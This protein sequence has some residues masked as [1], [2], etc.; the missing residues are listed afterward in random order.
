MRLQI[1]S[2]ESDTASLALF[3]FIEGVK[4]TGEVNTLGETR[5]V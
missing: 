2:W 1:N 5:P 3:C 4:H